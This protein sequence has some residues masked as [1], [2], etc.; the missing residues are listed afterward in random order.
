M[1][2]DEFD[3]LDALE[4][5]AKEYDKVRQCCQIARIMWL[6]PCAQDAEIDRILKAFKLDAYVHS[7]ILQSRGTNIVAVMQSWTYSLVFQNQTS[8]SYTAKNLY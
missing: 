6:T 4:K 2:N 7:A 3:A 5:E 1:A 8:R